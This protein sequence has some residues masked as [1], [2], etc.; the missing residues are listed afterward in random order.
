MLL[1]LA[2]LAGCILYLYFNWDTSPIAGEPETLRAAS[3][4][5]VTVQRRV[6]VIAAHPDDVEWYVGGTMLRMTG[7]GSHVTLVVATDG[8]RGRGRNQHPDLGAVRRAEAVEAGRRLGVAEVIPL[9]LAD[10]RL[11]LNRQLQALIR[12]VWERVDPEVV[13]TFDSA[14][15]RFPYVHPDHQAVGRAVGAIYDSL[16]GARPQLYLFHSRRPDTVVDVTNTI[17]AKTHA[18]GAHQSQGFS[19]RLHPYISSR[20]SSGAG[21]YIEADYGEAFRKR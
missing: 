13:F 15:P 8:E 18:L 21:R 10:T 11:L 12:E 5:L 1:I 6:L 19:S 14:Y 17:Q 9:G 16:A 3:E 20:M 4:E 2:V 7:A